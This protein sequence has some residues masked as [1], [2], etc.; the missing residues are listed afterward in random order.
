M[1]WTTSPMPAE[2]MPAILGENHVSHTRHL[3]VVRC[4]LVFPIL[5]QYMG[6]VVV[7]VL[8]TCGVSFLINGLESRYQGRAFGGDESVGVFDGEGGVMSKQLLFYCLQLLEFFLFVGRLFRY[9]LNKDD[10]GS[11]WYT[12]MSWQ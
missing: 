5:L 11:W 9:I 3:S 10:W 1:F 8:R 12:T 6:N 4:I 7:G 2:S